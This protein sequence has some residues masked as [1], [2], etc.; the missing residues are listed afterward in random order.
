[1]KSVFVII[2][3]IFLFVNV[4]A[5]ERTL[6]LFNEYDSSKIF[7]N[8]NHFMK[9]KLMNDIKLQGEIKI[10]TDSTIQ[11]EQK[12]IPLRMISE[13]SIRRNGKSVAPIMMVVGMI[14]FKIGSDNLHISITGDGSYQPKN[15]L[16][17]NAQAFC[18][19][20]CALGLAGTIVFV[21]KLFNKKRHLKN[22]D[23]KVYIINS[24]AKK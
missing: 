17:K 4:Q 2:V 7:L 5:Q 24:E 12:E 21:V 13:I 14:L 3:S 10:P 15:F 22:H 18:L 11:I 20:G 9:V 1:M 19:G 8:E 23:W 16:E 6:V